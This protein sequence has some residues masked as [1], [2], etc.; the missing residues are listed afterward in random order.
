MKTTKE[1]RTAFLSVILGDGWITKTGSAEITHCSSQL[2]YLQWKRKYL[3][4]KGVECGAIRP[5]NNSGFPAYRLYIKTTSYGKLYR[6][7]LY[8]DGYKNIYRRKLL[9]KLNR[10]H[11]AIWYMDDGGLSHKKRNGKIHANELFLNT[12]TTKENNQIIID[13]FCDVW[14]ISFTQVK[15]RGHYRIR[16]GTKEA[17]KFLAVVQEYVSQVP[18][19]IHK[20]NIKL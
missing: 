3:V 7:V 20:L 19:M 4:S 17:R 6:K 5:F 14:D 12:H 18:C 16:C 1:T 8:K 15:N 9:N 11:L 2:D 13:Y 10:E